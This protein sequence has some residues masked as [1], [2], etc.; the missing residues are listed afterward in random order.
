MKHRIEIQSTS[1]N[2]DKI[3]EVKSGRLILEFKVDKIRDKFGKQ[4]HEIIMREFND[5]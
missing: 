4:D 5:A 3:F 2:P 1:T